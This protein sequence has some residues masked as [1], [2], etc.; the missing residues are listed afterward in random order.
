MADLADISEERIE[1]ERDLNIRNALDAMLPDLPQVIIAGDDGAPMI[2]CYDCGG[3]IPPARLAAQPHAIR[4]IECQT[5]EE[6]RA[7]LSG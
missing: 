2:I 3:P 6:H 7:R 5:I 4:C 1:F